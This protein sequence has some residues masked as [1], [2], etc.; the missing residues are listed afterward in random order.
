MWELHEAKLRPVSV[1]SWAMAGLAM[2]RARKVSEATSILD[3]RCQVF[4]QVVHK[5]D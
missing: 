2:A 3:L 5:M 1:A 4:V